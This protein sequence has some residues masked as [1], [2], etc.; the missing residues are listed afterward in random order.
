MTRLQR[1]N[2]WLETHWV[3][4][5]YGGLV[6]GGIA[7]CF[8]GAATNTMAGWLYVISGSILA[9]L[10]LGGV[11]PQKAI[12]A[13]KVRRLPL[14]PIAT[15]DR[16]SLILE[17]EN[18]TN[19]AKTLLQVSDRLPPWLAPPTQTA[20]E[21]IPPQSTHR[22]VATPVAQ[23]RGIYHW[24]EVQLRSASPLGVFWCQRSRQVPAKLVVYPKVL[25][26]KQAPLLDTLGRDDSFQVD[27]DRRY[28]DANEGITR[29]LRPYRVGDP[30]RLIHWRSSARFGEFQVRELETIISGQEVIIGLDTAATWNREIFEQAVTAAASLYFYANR[31]QLSVKLWTASTGVVSGNRVVLETLAAT[32]PE[33]ARNH[34]DFPNVPWVWITQHPESLRSLPRG[35]RGLWFV[36]EDGGKTS[37]ASAVCPTLVITPDED[38]ALQLARSPSTSTRL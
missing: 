11:L 13:L 10:V 21:V 8:F 30:T 16:F 33:E 28:Q 1:L 22:W 15:G 7:I 17:I 12:K 24:Q 31:C 26:L 29:T 20:I 38:L 37:E 27:R 32:L 36:T 9:L 35:S 25:P 18:P 5:A 2:H 3:S 6:L 19:Q 34:D 4:P 23:H 14:Q